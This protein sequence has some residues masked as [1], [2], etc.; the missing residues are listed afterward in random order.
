MEKNKVILH[1]PSAT[2]WL[3]SSYDEHDSDIVFITE[4]RDVTDGG[5][6]LEDLASCTDNPID[7][8][9]LA[10][11][12]GVAS[13]DECCIYLRMWTSMVERKIEKIMYEE[14]VESD[15]YLN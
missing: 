1:Q 8:V 14:E 9:D 12:L 5:L 2:M 6:C 3:V 15:D 4:L 13:K 11:T 7:T 10:L